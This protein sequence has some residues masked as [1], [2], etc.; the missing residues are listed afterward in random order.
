[1][2]LL[3]IAILLSVGCSNTNTQS[4]YFTFQQVPLEKIEE[5]E[6]N[7]NSDKKSIKTP[8]YVSA[9][10][11]PEAQELDLAPYP[12]VY[13][14]EDKSFEPIPKVEVMYHYT[15]SDNTLRLIT[16]TWDSKQIGDNLSDINSDHDDK[17]DNFTTKYS[18]IYNQISDRLG[19]PEHSDPKAINK[20]EKDYGKWLEKSA[21]WK[22]ED[23]IV[24]LKLV[25]TQG[26][27]KLGTHSIRV[28]VYWTN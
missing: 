28:K 2:K 23:S 24:E 21:T 8:I 6:A 10:F 12:L 27:E 13:V 5:I 19:T 22:H 17:L 3:L 14:R 9:D 16:Y 25:F 20:Q 11:L 4:G 15:S 1:M 7:F 18:L 26:V